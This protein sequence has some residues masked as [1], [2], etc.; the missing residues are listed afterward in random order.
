MATLALKSKNYA[1]AKSYIDKADIQSKL[2]SK[3]ILTSA[4]NSAYGDYYKSLNDYP[5]AAK[6]YKIAEH[7]SAIYNKEQYADLLKSLTAVEILSGTQRD[8][9]GYFNKYATLSD[10]LTQSKIILNLAEM[11]AQYQNRNKQERIDVFAKE[12][13]ISH[14]G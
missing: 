12:S 5:Q 6:Y 8:A 10:S 2:D 13:I 1:A 9:A 11:E 3:E 14:L 7:G 4:V